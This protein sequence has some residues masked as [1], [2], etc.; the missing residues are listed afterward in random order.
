[1]I[2][3]NPGGDESEAAWQADAVG[4]FI[5]RIF[6]QPPRH[7]GARPPIRVAVKDLI[8]MVGLPTTAGSRVVAQQTRPAAADGACMAGIRAA[9][10][11]GEVAI[12]GKTGLH[13]LAFGVTGVNQWFGTPTNP[14]DAARVPGGSSSGS[15]VAVATDEADVGIGSDTGGSVRIPA[16]CCGVA[17][18]K[19]T[20]GLISAE[21]TWPLAPTLDTIGPLARDVAGLRVG[22]ALL[23]PAGAEG[24]ADGGRSTWASVARLR[25]PASA[26]IDAAI[27]AALRTAELGIV[28]IELGGWAGADAAATTILLA[29]AW[30]SDRHLIDEGLGDDVATRL[31]SGAPITA[32]EI[33]AARQ[34]RDAWRAELRQA[35]EDFG[36]IAIPTLA[37][38]PPRLDDAARTGSLR[39]TLPVNLAGFPAVNLPAP[40]AGLPAGLQLVGLPNGES[41]LLDLAARIEAAVRR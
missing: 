28:D 21:G 7:P 30:A 18:L 29:E 11:R 36:P 41:D 31:R 8:D 9:E 20:A 23:D 12:V 26:D 13:E 2:K 5:E 15:A 25:L 27:D 37:E 40:K 3:P 32:A 16:T 14:L 4:T 17:G 19:T 6:P 38:D 24:Y 39:H 1:V 33:A 35:I 34:V 10:S 22:M